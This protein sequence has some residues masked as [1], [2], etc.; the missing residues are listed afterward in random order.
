VSGAEPARSTTGAALLVCAGAGLFGTIG[1][2]RALGPD[3]ASSSGITLVR[4]LLAI[5]LMWLAVVVTGRQR[6]LGPVLRAGPV[7]AAGLAQ[8]VFQVAFLS[9][10]T[11]VGVATGTLVAIGVTPLLA[12]LFQAVRTRHLSGTW[13]V[14]TACGLVGLVLLVGIDD[15]A[16]TAGL[17]LALAASAAY[18]VFIVLGGSIGVRELD[19]TTVLPVVFTVA[20]AVQ[21]PALA[22]ADWDWLA[23]DSGRWMVVY[24]ALA[25]TVLAYALFNRGLTGVDSATASTVGLVEPLVATA[26]AVLVLGE[27]LGPVQAVGA[28]LVG[29]GVVLAARAPEPYARIES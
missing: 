8:A 5:S 4:L 20:A 28:V 27:S 1:T 15:R 12:G 22:Y 19:I 13:V 9:S 16:D 10:V 14:A 29:A 25:P 21:L 24:L 7:W 11:R 6:R 2:A 23:T 18:A 3:D 17:L 26:L